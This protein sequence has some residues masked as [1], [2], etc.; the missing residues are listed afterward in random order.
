MSRLGSAAGVKSIVIFVAFVFLFIVAILLDLQYLYLMAVTLAVLP[1]ASYGLAALFA[2]RFTATRTHASTVLEGRQTPVTLDVA[3]AGGL[4]Q[5]AL[6]VADAVPEELV[7]EGE[8]AAYRAARPL[9]VWDGV[10]GVQ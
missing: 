1:L 4:P 6:R 2:A 9:D 7:P 8:E 5:A 3:A 10:E